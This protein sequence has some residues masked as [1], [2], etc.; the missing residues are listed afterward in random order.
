MRAAVC[1]AGLA[2]SLVRE[3]SVFLAFMNTQRKLLV[4][5]R[6]LA[7]GGTQLGTPA[8]LRAKAGEFKTN[9]KINHWRS[10]PGPPELAGSYVDSVWARGGG[11]AC[12]AFFAKTHSRGPVRKPAIRHRSIEAAAFQPEPAA[13]ETEP[14]KVSVKTMKET[15]RR[16]GLSTADMLEKR[17]IEARYKQAQ[18]RLEE[19]ER[20]LRVK[21]RKEVLRLRSLVVRGRAKKSSDAIIAP[22]FRLPDGVF[23]N[24]LSF[25][26]PRCDYLY[27]PAS[28]YL[29]LIHI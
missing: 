14:T 3:L 11:S 17:D 1:C 20:R 9:L 13:M 28:L 4:S 2:A 26:P 18:A 5:Y 10:S 16:A 12:R 15:I 6:T 23:W 22:S 8:L 19:R 7:N 21:K 27:L 29:S 25:W 24:V